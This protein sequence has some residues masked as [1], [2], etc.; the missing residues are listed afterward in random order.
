M[1]SSLPCWKMVASADGSGLATPPAAERPTPATLDRLAH[2]YGLQKDLD[3][4]WALC[5]L[6]ST[7]EGGCT[8]LEYPG[9]GPLERLLGVVEPAF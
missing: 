9:G 6:K 5:P 4:A 1:P 3:G 2:E 7:R 8:T